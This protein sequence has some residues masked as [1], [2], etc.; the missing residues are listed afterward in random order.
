MFGPLS[1]T[2]PEGWSRRE[3]TPDS[4]P[5]YEATAAGGGKDAAILLAAEDPQPP[6][7]AGTQG[8]D[9]LSTRVSTIAGRRATIETWHH[10]TTGALGQTIS[11]SDLVPGKVIRVIAWSPK[12]SWPAWKPELQAILAS[13]VITEGEA[14]PPSEPTPQAITHPPVSSPRDDWRVWE[15][16]AA[17][18]ATPPGLTPFSDQPPLT[19]AQAWDAVLLERPDAPE[20]G[21]FLRLAWSADPSPYSADLDGRSILRTSPF[22]LGEVAATATEFRLI[23]KFNNTRGIDVVTDQTIHGGYLTITCRM[24]AKRWQ[25]AGHVCAEIVNSFVI[26]Q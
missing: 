15:F 4:Q 3:D 11:F 6:G 2:L 20:T 1:L 26:G 25:K 21:L 7:K 10:A 24:P 8:V 13:I 18:L 16:G 9:I 12:L 22:Q 19:Y 14:L 17:A 23:D 5:R